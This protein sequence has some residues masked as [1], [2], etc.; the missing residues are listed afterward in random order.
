MSRPIQSPNHGFTLIELV[1]VIVILG[2]LAATALPK[3]VDLGGDGRIAA[4]NNLAG[5]MKTAAELAHGKCLATPN[6]QKFN[7]PTDNVSVVGNVQIRNPEGKLGYMFNGYPTGFSRLPGYFGIKDWVDITGFTIYETG[8]GPD[9]YFY[10]DGAPDSSKC[11][12]YY[13]ETYDPNK[14]P[15]IKTETSGCKA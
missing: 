3:F 5:A 14:P 15:T 2:I 6:C 8:T 13:L 9:A 11:Y 12:V 1:V 4:V 7:L 10:K